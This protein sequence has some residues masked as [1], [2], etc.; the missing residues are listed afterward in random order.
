MTVEVGEAGAVVGDE[1]EKVVVVV[2]S[3]EVSI[4]GPVRV[5]HT[6]CS[7]RVHRARVA[8]PPATT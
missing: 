4:L 6:T 1:E 8:S 3:R 7:K 2:I 5:P